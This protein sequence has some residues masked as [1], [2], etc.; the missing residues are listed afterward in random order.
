[1]KKILDYEITDGA[2]NQIEEILGLK[3]DI[4]DISNDKL[5]YAIE[6]SEE[7]I[8]CGNNT[9][10]F[11]EEDMNAICKLGELPILFEV[12]E[13]NMY[14]TEDCSDGLYYNEGMIGD[15]YCLY[16]YICRDADD[17]ERAFAEAVDDIRWYETDNE[18]YKMIEEKSNEIYEEDNNSDSIILVGNG[19][20]IDV[21]K[22][23]YAD[24]DYENVKYSK[25]GY[26][27][28]KLIHRVN[29]KLYYLSDSSYTFNTEYHFDLVEV[30]ENVYKY[31]E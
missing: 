13:L 21:E 27:S 17:T 23:L 22:A 10:I 1:M 28:G 31:F 20:G 6:K 8:V 30:G 15:D 7:L 2:I 11:I 16:S 19:F 12:K 18:L 5:K 14:F 24:E 4:D 29:D 25:M 9:Y 26:Y 3:I